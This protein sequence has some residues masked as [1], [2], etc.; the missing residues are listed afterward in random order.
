M[1]E[2][3]LFVGLN[4]NIIIQ[5]KMWQKKAHFVDDALNSRSIIYLNA[6]TFLLFAPPLSKFLATRLVTSIHCSLQ[7]TQSVVAQRVLPKSKCF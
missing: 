5:K 3:F 1:K 7:V 6:D 2:D 4:M